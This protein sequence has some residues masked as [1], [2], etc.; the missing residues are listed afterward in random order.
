M[1]CPTENVWNDIRRA[2]EGR[3]TITLNPEQCRELVTGRDLANRLLRRLADRVSEQ[4]ECL[5]RAAEHNRNG[6]GK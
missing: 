4:S 2:A 3:V 6:G 5:A 1:G